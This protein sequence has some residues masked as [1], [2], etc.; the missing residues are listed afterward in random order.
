MEIAELRPLGAPGEQLV[1]E[2]LRYVNGLGLN[3]LGAAL[4]AKR[5]AK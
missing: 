1:G 3:S 4:D 2:T 5:L